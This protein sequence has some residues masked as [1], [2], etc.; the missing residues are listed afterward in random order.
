MPQPPPEVHDTC[1]CATSTHIACTPELMCT[2]Y[3]HPMCKHPLNLQQSPLHRYFM[4]EYVTW[5][6]CLTN[7]LCKRLPCGYV[8]LVVLHSLSKGG[9]G[10]TWVHLNVEL[11]HRSCVAH[12]QGGCMADTIL[13]LYYG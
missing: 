4:G 11:L 9:H 13:S 7:Q 8:T 5:T 12:L 6:F 2:P 3:P 10:L 1:T